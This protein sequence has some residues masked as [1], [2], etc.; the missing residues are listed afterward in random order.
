[1]DAEET[2]HYFKKGVKNMYKKTTK[3]VSNIEN[4]FTNYKDKK[5]ETIE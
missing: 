2:F 3:I 1:M 4:K 5:L